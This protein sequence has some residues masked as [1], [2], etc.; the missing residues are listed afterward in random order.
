MTT[1]HQTSTTDVVRTDDRNIIGYITRDFV[2]HEI[3]AEPLDPRQVNK[4][5]NE[6]SHSLAVKY[7]EDCAQ[8]TEQHP[9][10]YCEKCGELL[11]MDGRCPTQW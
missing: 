3:N 6:Y 11:R 4:V 8:V 10:E 7:I 5:F 2:V 1:L 9:Y